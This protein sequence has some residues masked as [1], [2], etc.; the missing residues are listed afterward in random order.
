MKQFL[1]L[2]FSLL[3][4]ATLAIAQTGE[5]RLEC[6]TGDS[7]RALAA[8][9]GPEGSL[10]ILGSVDNGFNNPVG[11]AN[12]AIV[13]RIDNDNQVEWAQEYDPGTFQSIAD[14]ATANDGGFV[15][16]GTSTTVYFDG[17]LAKGNPDGTLE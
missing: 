10:Y 5:F 7:V 11:N 8:T 6:T 13:T 1:F 9:A 15:L 2:L 4:S 3:L 12:D 17:F 14:I 16:S